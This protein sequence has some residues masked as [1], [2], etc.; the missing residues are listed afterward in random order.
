M[1]PDFEHDLLVNVWTHPET[2]V[3]ILG[4]DMPHELMPWTPRE[5]RPAVAIASAVIQLTPIVQPVEG[6]CPAC[7]FDALV[8][9]R[10]YHLSE[11]G[12]S[13]LAGRIQCARCAAEDA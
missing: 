13:L 10:V 4:E 3:L 7:R 1:S 11:R 8:Y 6:E 12:A 5:E 2:G 9:L